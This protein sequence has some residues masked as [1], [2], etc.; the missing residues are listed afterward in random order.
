M[1][2]LGCFSFYATK[3]ITTGEGGMVVSHDRGLVEKVKAM[4]MNGLSADAWQRFSDEGYRHYLVT[5][6]GFKYNM[7]DIQ[8]AMGIHQ[9]EKVDVFRR[10]REEIWTYYRENLQRLPVGLPPPVESRTRHAYHLFTIRV[11]E[12]K[13]GIARDDFLQEMTMRNIGTGVHYLSIAEH[14]YYQKAFGWDPADF[15]HA[16]KY[17]SET[18]SL[19]LS[20]KLS[21]DDAHDVVEA[22]SDLL[23]P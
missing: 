11:D 18:V 16:R 17:G 9:L 13:A 6:L 23:S 5:S 8:A 19:P 2:E 7:T 20:P 3:N 12:D 21:D 1:G 4:A 10:R 14:P 15:P 22:I